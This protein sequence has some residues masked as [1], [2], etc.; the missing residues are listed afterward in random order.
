MEGAE[1]AAKQVVAKAKSDEKAA[2][3]AAAEGAKP[4]LPQNATASRASGKQLLTPPSA[5]AAKDEKKKA[6]AD[7]KKAAGKTKK[8]E[9]A[10]QKAQDKEEK[11][12]SKKRRAKAKLAK[13]KAIAKEKA[14]AVSAPCPAS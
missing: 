8:A 1:D 5:L 4:P 9:K 6:E 13:D 12:E 11:L 10:A 14:K 7:A 2:E 3:K